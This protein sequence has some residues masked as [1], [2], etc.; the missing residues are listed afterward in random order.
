MILAVFITV[1]VL[2]QSKNAGL[3]H[4]LKG[5]FGAYRS[6]RGFEKFVFMFTVVCGILLV[7]N[8]ILLVILK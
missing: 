1:L 2:V 3:A 4:G 5:S 8:S 7:L 6:M